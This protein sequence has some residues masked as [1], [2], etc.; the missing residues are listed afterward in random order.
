MRLI[1]LSYLT[2]LTHHLHRGSPFH[3]PDSCVSLRAFSRCPYIIWKSDVLDQFVCFLFPAE[4]WGENG[5]RGMQTW[6]EMVFFASLCLL[7]YCGAFCL[8]KDTVKSSVIWVLLFL[9][10][11]SPTW[12][13]LCLHVSQSSVHWPK[14]FK[15][16]NYLQYI[17]V[18]ECNSET[19]GRPAPPKCRSMLFLHGVL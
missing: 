5:C 3:W 11:I 15:S 7:G 2:E 10:M 1:S 19:A 13:S 17:A 14:V 16:W 12:W 18:T 9:L 8:N 4:L 6:W